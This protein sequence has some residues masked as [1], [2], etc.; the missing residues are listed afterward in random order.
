M[1]S[2]RI[3]QI[4][5]LL[6]LATAALAIDPGERVISPN[7]RFAVVAIS[8]IEGQTEVVSYAIRLRATGKTLAICPKDGRFASWP[9]AVLWSPDSRYVAIFTRTQRHG[10]L[11]D[12]WEV[13]SGRT[14]L[15]SVD[16]SKEDFD[17]YV[18]PERWL[19]SRHLK[20]E[21]FGH[22][23]SEHRALHPNQPWIGYHLTIRIDRDSRRT[24]VVRTKPHTP[25]LIESPN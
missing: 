2:M 22:T 15:L 10:D 19:D 1:R 23:S 4:T 20:C 21:V 7:R 14:R 9:D 12:L 17:I 8:S 6:G 18:T 5:I 13:T 25:D 24:K 16:L 3:A 11:P